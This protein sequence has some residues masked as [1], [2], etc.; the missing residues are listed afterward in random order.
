MPLDAAHLHLVVNHLPVFGGPFLLL[1]L[2][3]G[4]IRR[5]GELV[6]LSLVLVV[7][8][9]AG[10]GLVYLTGEPAEDQVEKASWYQERLV[11]THEEQ[12]EAGLIAMLATGALAAAGLV[13]RKRPGTFPWLVRA[14]V[15]GLVVG[16][17]L[18]GRS[19]WSGGQIRHDEIRAGQPLSSP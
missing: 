2:V 19:A 5:S 9:A 17:V 15:A 7:L 13:L 11:E 16:T 12:S 4:L 14:T 10:T 1:L 8:L 18:I 6:T 3:L